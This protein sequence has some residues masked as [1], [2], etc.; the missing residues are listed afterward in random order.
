MSSN[1]AQVQAQFGARA[2]DYATSPVHADP[3]S[4]GRLVTLLQPAPTWQVLDVA[5]GAGHTAHAFAPHVAHVVATDVTG[6]MAAK[7]QALAGEKG[8]PNVTSAVAAAEALPFAADHFD[9]V[10]CRLAAHHFPDRHEFLAE[11]KRI[12][13]PGG[14]LLLV[15]NV[16]P[17]SLRS[18][19]KARIQNEAGRYI[20]ALER[21]RDPSHARCLSIYEWRQ[22]FLAAGFVV[23]QESLDWK[24]LAFG[25]WAARMGVT[26]PTLTRLRVLLTRAPE[27]VLE[28]LTP[29]IAA[30]TIRF[31]LSE[32]LFVVRKEKL[33]VRS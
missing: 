21:L 31:R 3:E 6:S 15:D 4:L 22:A 12:L 17:G 28:F 16:V 23:E 20:N 5:T 18:G 27:E 25:P 1:R 19:K 32:A 33:E 7:A 8:L 24:W 2:G 10:T 14:R 9:L 30:G 29:Q 13:R 26:E 11:A